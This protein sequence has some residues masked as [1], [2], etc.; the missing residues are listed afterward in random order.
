MT[1]DDQITQDITHALLWDTRVS[2]ARIE[3]T[4]NEGVVSLS[5]TV[6]SYV[7]K[8]SAEETALGIADVVQ[9]INN[10]VVKPKSKV[11]DRA[12]RRNI[13]RALK[14]DI[15]LDSREIKVSVKKG[16]VAL[17]G[18][19]NSLFAKFSAEET[20][21]WIKG[22][23]DVKNEL[24]VVRDSQVVDKEDSR[25]NRASLRQEQTAQGPEHIDI[26]RKP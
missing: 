7:K 4:T 25:G 16:V 24:E 8:R 11:P 2:A 10:V 22:V 20:C 12:I 26:C 1:S 21:R 3:V 18:A 5:G 6:D 19:T 23:T 14:S 15:R 17:A 9:V 13:K